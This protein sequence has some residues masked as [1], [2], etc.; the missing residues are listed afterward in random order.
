MLIFNHSKSENRRGLTIIEVLT[1][2][3]VA[4]I[5]VFGIM[6]LIPFAIKQTESGLDFDDANRLARNA[7]Q[8]L[9]VNGH[10]RLY[11]GLPPWYAVNSNS[12]VYL[13]G[14]LAVGTETPPPRN[15]VFVIDPLSIYFGDPDGPD[16][17]LGNADDL[18]PSFEQFPPQS[19]IEF[20]N[21]QAG[22]PRELDFLGGGPTPRDAFPFFRH[23]NLGS[24][25]PT[26]TSAAR[27][28]LVQMTREEAVR[29]L[30]T[31]DDL[32]FGDPVSDP[33]QPDLGLGVLPPKMY[34]DQNAGGDSMRRQSRGEM[35][36]MSILAPQKDSYLAQSNAWQ[37]RQ[38][39][40]VFE[41]RVF[42]RSA[43][44]Y[45]ITEVISTGAA[46]TAAS[47][48]RRT[49]GTITI[50]GTVSDVRRDDWIMLVNRDLSPDA[51]PGFEKQ[52]GFY[53]VVNTNGDSRI[54]LDGPDFDFGPNPGAIPTP[55]ANTVRTTYAVH[56]VNYDR[57]AFEADPTAEG[58]QRMG[59]VVNV[60]ERQLGLK[61]DS[62]WTQ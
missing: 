13:C 48:V 25:D 4:M 30:R 40:L 7:I 42:D 5:G 11:D 23:V 44:F 47:G 46:G 8:Y 43:F 3:V 35:S 34:F 27:R 26:I 6:I 39:T 56:L 1:A 51:Q 38:Y 28:Q 55:P 2:M 22:Y 24:F 60:Y 15:D 14:S 52:I 16:N 32:E 61:G 37:F 58:L 31:S 41:N 29:A 10:D 17:V 54:T 20:A 62:N 12:D 50:D 36:W 59:S 18:T 57:A 21:N 53:R 45:P 9:Q 33:A 19:S 49:G